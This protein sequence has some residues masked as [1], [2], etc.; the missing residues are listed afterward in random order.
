MADRVSSSLIAMIVAG[1]NLQNLD[2]VGFSLGAQ[3]AGNSGRQLKR[4][5]RR[6]R[7][8]TRIVG[9]DPAKLSAV[10][11]GPNDADFVMTTHTGNFYGET[12]VVG[13]VGFYYNGGV[14]QPGCLSFDALCQHGRAQNYW[15]EAVTTQSATVFPA[16]KCA[17]YSAFLKQTCIQSTAVGYVN[18]KTPNNLRGKY[19]LKTNANSPYTKT[20][21]DP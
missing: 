6:T 11:L 15:I 10:N 5:T 8:F 4:K 1:Y 14:Y 20:T 2:V 17:S 21:A 9:L 7:S 18:T 13:H 16:R 12:N 3:L 19:W